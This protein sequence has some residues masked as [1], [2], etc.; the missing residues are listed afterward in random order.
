MTKQTSRERLIPAN[1]DVIDLAEQRRRN[2]LYVLDILLRAYVP[3]GTPD[4]R[5]MEAALRELGGKGDHK[6]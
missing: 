1:A 6:P 4:W 2:A 3:K 5:E